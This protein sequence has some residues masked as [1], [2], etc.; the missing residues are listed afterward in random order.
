MTCQELIALLAEFLDH[1][2]DAQ[3][4]AA[5][6]AHLADCPPCQA[7][8]NTYRKTRALTHHAGQEEMPAEMK[9][10]L[11]DFLLERLRSGPA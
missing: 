1:T 8:L 10:R 11:R 4:L 3:A 6:E 2:L 7:Y 5:F 9:R